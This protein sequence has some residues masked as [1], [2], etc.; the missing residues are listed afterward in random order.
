MTVAAVL[1]LATHEQ[2]MSNTLATHWQH[3]SNTVYS[4][5]AVF[6]LDRVCFFA[7][8]SVLSTVRLFFVLG[9]ILRG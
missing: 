3:I 5:S 8:E 1:S 6:S 9:S 4:L 2:H 7:I